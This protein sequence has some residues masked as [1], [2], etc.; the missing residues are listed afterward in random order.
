VVLLRR[1]VRQQTAIIAGKLQFEA[2]AEERARVARELHDTVEQ[3]LAVVAMHL[4]TIR[5]QSLPLPPLVQENLDAAYHQVRHSQEDAHHAVWDLR[6]ATLSERGLTAALEEAAA[7]ARA[8]FGVHSQ[9]VVR[10][11]SRRLDS[12][13]EHHLLRMGQEAITNAVRHGHPR[14]ISVT[15]T[16]EDTSIALRVEDNG[17]GFDADAKANT[18]ETLDHFGLQGMRERAAK[19]GAFLSIRSVPGRGSTVEVALPTREDRAVA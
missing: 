17:C 6:S 15:L 14:E 16:Y 18:T 19:I 5:D 2:T 7:Q 13:V 12:V 3:D 9:C 10:G 11:R 1:R 8:C 4:G